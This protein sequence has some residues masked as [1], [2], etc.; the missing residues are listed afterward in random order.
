M[1]V[2]SQSWAGT[3]EAEGGRWVSLGLQQEAPR[4]FCKL[5]SG[6]I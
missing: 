3:L 6:I 1:E 5:D 2:R 4:L